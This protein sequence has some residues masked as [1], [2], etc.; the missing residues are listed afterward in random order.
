M[1]KGH[2]GNSAV[3]EQK[4]KAVFLHPDIPLERRRRPTDS[5]QRVSA[6]RDE[7]E[8][9]ATDLKQTRRILPILGAIEVL[10]YADYG[11]GCI[12][13]T[14]KRFIADRYTP[15]FQCVFSSTRET[16]PYFGHLQEFVWDAKQPEFLES[17]TTSKEA[18]EMDSLRLEAL[19]LMKEIFQEILD[20]HEEVRLHLD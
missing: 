7:I 14:M 3:G 17:L 10:L 11:K 9:V 2:G 12:K 6:V 20:E 15:S 1:G 16:L 5:I 4:E 8:A 19:E 13:Q 18:N